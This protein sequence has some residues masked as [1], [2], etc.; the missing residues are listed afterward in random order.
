MT[1]TNGMGIRRKITISFTSLAALLLLSWVVTVFELRRL[2][3]ET[4]ALFDSSAKNMELARQ[5]LD[6]LEGQSAAVIRLNFGE[7]AGLD[8]VFSASDAQIN[9]LLEK[10]TVTVRDRNEMDAIY[11]SYSAYRKEIAMLQDKSVARGVWWFVNVYEPAYSGLLATIKDY[12]IASQQTMQRKAS[13][14]GSTAYRAVT[15]GMLALVVGIVILMMFLYLIDHY[16]AR[17]VVAINKSL[18]GYVANRIPFKVK[19]EGRDEVAQLKEQIEDL[20]QSKKAD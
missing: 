5:M 7:T 14:L 10:A 9:E 17:P 18:K 11:S 4:E 8:S 20:V 15:P 6:A 13:D 12:M 16:F 19:V 2:D 3:V 1:K